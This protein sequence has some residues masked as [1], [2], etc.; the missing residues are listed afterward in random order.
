MTVSTELLMASAMVAATV[1]THL[2]GLAIL[3]ALLRRHRKQA[4]RLKAAMANG[5]VV[6]A[7]AFGLF[8]LHTIE[9]WCWALAY[10][11]L[12][13]LPHWEQALYFSTTTYV[14]IGYGDIVLPQGSRIFGAIEGANGI[15][16]LGWSTAFFFGIVDR[17]KL[18]EREFSGDRP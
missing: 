7:S 12:G 18:L 3:L 14:T 1:L 4:S 5:F 11:L 2:S 10:R 9:I 16:L 17:M 13:M 6:M 8:A 15:I